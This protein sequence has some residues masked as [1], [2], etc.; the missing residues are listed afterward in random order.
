MN[1][2]TNCIH[3]EFGVNCCELDKDNRCVNFR[4]KKQRREEEENEKDQ[5]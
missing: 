1:K 4:A 5:K 3:N 2:C